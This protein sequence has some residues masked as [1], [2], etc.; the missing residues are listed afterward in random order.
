MS[1]LTRA[2]QAAIQARLS[3]P[4]DTVRRAAT[5]LLGRALNGGAELAPA[6]W[7]HLQPLPLWPSP[8]APV[9]S[10]IGGLPLLPPGEPWPVGV[11]VF[12]PDAMPRPL[13]FIAQI[14][15]WEWPRLLPELSGVPDGLF[16]IFA[17]IDDDLT[18]FV[19]EY[20]RPGRAARVL[21]F[22][23]RGEGL[24]PARPPADLLPDRPRADALLPPR[25]F[26][27]TTG[28]SLNAAVADALQPRPPADLIRQGVLFLDR[29]A[30]EDLLAAG[31]GALQD[32]Q[33]LALPEAPTVAD[34]LALIAATHLARHEGGE[35]ETLAL[36]DR[37]LVE[38]PLTPL[39]RLA[40]PARPRLPEAAPSPLPASVA[41][42]LP[43]DADA[44]RRLRQGSANDATPLPPLLNLL[45]RVDRLGAGFA[46]LR[47]QA[48]HMLAGGFGVP[49]DRFDTAEQAAILGIDS[50]R[51]ARIGGDVADEIHG[52]PLRPGKLLL[53]QLPVA[54]CPGHPQA[55]GELLFHIDL[56]TLREG[57]IEGLEI[58]YNGA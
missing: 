1:R 51:A 58:R 5:E 11:P 38:D 52:P 27:C 32:S 33:A 45:A 35:G 50:W 2:E 16:V 34:A 7:P 42:L 6:L 48:L 3:A 14:A 39:A 55:D 56:G 31:L 15:S 44:Y 37:L 25:P 12:E 43:G 20:G 47:P 53:L 24:A 29:L 21:F 36:L 23:G 40:A 4:A 57:R 54:L 41:G 18:S 8:D 13:H 19:T 22:P 46:S 26:S 9:A 10:R 49:Q 28:I 17:L 30:G